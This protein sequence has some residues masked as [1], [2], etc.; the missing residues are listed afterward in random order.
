MNGPG[1]L[2]LTANNTY[3]GTTA[4]NGGTLRIGANGSTGSFGAG[5]VTDNGAL[6]ISRSDA[7]FTYGGA[8]GGTGSVAVTGSGTVRLTGANSYTGSTAISGGTLIFN[9]AAVPA[10]WER[11]GF[12]SPA[13]AASPSPPALSA[14]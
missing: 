6:V 4:I 7:A 11:R 3:A 2:L 1:T 5:D 13:A 9:G 12:P 8:I 14:P 10:L